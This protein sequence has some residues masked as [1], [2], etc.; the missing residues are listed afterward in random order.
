[1]SLTG[2]NR[3]L[4][5]CAGLMLLF[6]QT[7]VAQ[8]SNAKST[9]NIS[10][11]NVI[12][13]SVIQLKAH[14]YLNPL[15]EP[16]SITKLK[17]YIS[18]ITFGGND[19]KTLFKTDADFLVD[20][21]IDSSKT[22]SLKIPPGNYRSMS[23]LLGVD[24]IKNVSGAQTGALDPLNGMYWTWNSGYI[25]FKV[26]GQS[27]VSSL[28]NNHFEYHIGGFAGSQ[29][30]VRK[31]LINFPNDHFLKAESNLTYD[32]KLQADI[33]EIWSGAQAI[34]ITNIPACTTPGKLSVDIAD[35]LSKMFRLIDPTK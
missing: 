29:N 35:N 1:M 12:K 31:I 11:I 28:V 8:N 23:F 20:E 15:N 18:N 14:Q 30:T 9:V 27:P 5:L 2:K 34:N 7:L 32:I 19:S 33:N 6:S 10:F 21:A 24:S 22:V 13:D 16:F 25:M 4:F 3:I 26:E 17:Y